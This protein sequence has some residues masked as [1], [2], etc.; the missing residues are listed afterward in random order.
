MIF[1]ANVSDFYRLDFAQ[2][3]VE[4]LDPEPI[5]ILTPFGGIG[6]ICHAIDVDV[7]VREQGPGGIAVPCIPSAF[8]KMSAAE[9]A[10]VPKK[11]LP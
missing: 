4:L 5:V 7:K 6:L 2:R 11:S 3:C 1:R 8:H 10:A 9:V